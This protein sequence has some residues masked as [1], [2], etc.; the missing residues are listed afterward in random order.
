MKQ[1]V[2]LL[3]LLSILIIAVLIAPVN[4]LAVVEG[5]KIIVADG[6]TSPMVH[7]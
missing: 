7:C 5:E 4:A 2:I 6:A 3:T 1:Q